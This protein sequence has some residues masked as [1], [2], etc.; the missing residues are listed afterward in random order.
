M[1]TKILTPTQLFINGKFFCTVDSVEI[2]QNDPRFKKHL[3][4][5]NPKTNPDEIHG[6]V[7][8][9]IKKSNVAGEQ[10]EVKRQKKHETYDEFFNRMVAAVG[11][12]EKHRPVDTS[13]I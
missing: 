5:D 12:P 1:N 7:I 9:V 3:L 10:A 4:P 2:K 6:T 13:D 8:N 11:D